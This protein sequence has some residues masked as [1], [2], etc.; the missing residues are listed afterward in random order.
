MKKTSMLLIVFVLIGLILS[1]CPSTRYQDPSLDS[2]ESNQFETS[3]PDFQLQDLNDNTISFSDFSGQPIMLN[4]WATWCGPC[5]HEMPFIQ[6]VFENWQ[7]KDLVILTINLG[8]S[9]EKVSEFM[10]SNALTFPVLLDTNTNTADKYNVTAIPT[11]FF[12]DANGVIQERRIGSYSSTEDIEN[13]VHRI[14][15]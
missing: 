6:Q 3:L 1:G 10:R 11:T 12:I 8:E 2:R 7:G 9:K 14:S 15:K 4:F 13:H 5:R